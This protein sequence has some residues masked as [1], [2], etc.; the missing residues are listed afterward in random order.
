LDVI[1]LSPTDVWCITFLEEEEDAAFIGSNE[2]FWLKRHQSNPDKK[3]LSPLLSVNR[4]GSIVKQLFDLYEVS[5]PIHK[6]VLSRNGYL[7]YPLV[8]YDI[9]LLDKRNYS[10]WFDKMRKLSAP[11][12]HHQL[13]AAQALLEYCQTTSSR[14]LEWDVE[15]D[16]DGRLGTEQES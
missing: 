5:L 10:D 1:L 15:A 6:V 9:L 11:L 2:R 3:V 4:M 13:K 8:P 16:A 7:D 12:K 14:R